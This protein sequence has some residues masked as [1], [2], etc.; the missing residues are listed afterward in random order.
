MPGR[1]ENMVPPPF[2]P[3]FLAGIFC[4]AQFAQSCKQS[5]GLLRVF[6]F[7]GW[8]LDFRRS[9]AVKKFLIIDGFGTHTKGT[10]SWGPRHLVGT[11]SKLRVS[12]MAF[13]GVFKIY[14]PPRMPFNIARFECF[15][16]LFKYAINVIQNWETDASQF[17]LIWCFFFISSYNRR[18]QK[19]LAKD[20]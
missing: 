8:Y 9:R 15:T 3:A 6:K 5:D 13:P 14:F 20:G 19:W 16:D 12:E 2:L 1:T 7:L 10:S 11:F 4:L 17:Y 18:R